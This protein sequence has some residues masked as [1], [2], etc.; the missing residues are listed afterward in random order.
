MSESQESERRPRAKSVSRE[1][2]KPLLP[3]MLANLGPWRAHL[4]PD[5]SMLPGSHTHGHTRRATQPTAVTTTMHT[6]T[7]VSMDTHTHIHCHT[8]IRGC[9]HDSYRE[10]YAPCVHTGTH[11]H[12]RVHSLMFPSPNSSPPAS[13]PSP[14]T[15]SRTTIPFALPFSPML[16]FLF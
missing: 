10:M 16:G 4:L 7:C 11:V 12:V 6:V 5:L 1:G 3:A 14:H 9:P 2:M 15:F 8:F 13:P